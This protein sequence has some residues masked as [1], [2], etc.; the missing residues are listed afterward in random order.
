MTKRPKTW[1]C[2]PFTA[3]IAS[4]NLDEGMGV[5]LSCLL[6]VV[7]VAAFATG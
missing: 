3:G 2:G 7:Y 6:C 5:R 4:L 1:V